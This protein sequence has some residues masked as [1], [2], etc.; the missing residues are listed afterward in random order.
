MEQQQSIW[1]F[2][3]APHPDQHFK[4]EIILLSG[5]HP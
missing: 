2:G 4:K 1:D 5:A 3:Y